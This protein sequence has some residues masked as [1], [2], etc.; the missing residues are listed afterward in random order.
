MEIKR[1]DET[2]IRSTPRTR[3]EIKATFYEDNRNISVL[4]FQKFNPR[5][6][7]SDRLHFSFIRDEIPKLLEFI[8]NI[9]RVHLKDPSKLNITDSD[10]N[11]IILNSVQARQVFN[12]HEEE[13]LTLAQNE[14]LT[15]DLI[16][17]GYRRAQLEY[18]EKLLSDKDYFARE[19]ADKTPEAIWQ[20]FFEKN[21]WIF[22]YGLSYI[23]LDGL[24]DKK[25]EQVTSGYSLSKA[26]KRADALL[27][28]RAEI[29]ALCFVEIKRPDTP[30]LSSKPYRAEVWQPSSEL[31]GGLAQVQITVN[32]A[33]EELGRKLTPTDEE[34]NPTGEML[35]NIAPRSFLVVGSLDQFKTATGINESQYRSFE[36]FRRNVFQPEVLTFDEL[37]HRARYIVQHS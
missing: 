31:V 33:F 15:R 26:G 3:Q 11:Q 35:F 5:T 9:Q 17:V 12:D 8:R 6:G 21:K 1:I 37:L 32:S 22:G 10:L 36:L 34:G 18:F 14:T 27:K 19:V 4:T 20:A 24:Q 2:I 7:P 30:L 23:F 28:T 16:A 13:F 25:L 29:S